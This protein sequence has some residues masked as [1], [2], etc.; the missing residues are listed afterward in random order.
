MGAVVHL[1]ESMAI[2][3]EANQAL[4]ATAYSLTSFS[5]FSFLFLCSEI[6]LI[7]LLFKRF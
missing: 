1:L 7:A 6:R 2:A 4:I 3:L 5:I